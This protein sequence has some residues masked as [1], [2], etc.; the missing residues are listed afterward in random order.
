MALISCFT[1]PQGLQ[2]MLTCLRDTEGMTGILVVVALLAGWIAVQYF[3]DARCVRQAW[4]SRPGLPVPLA[5]FGSA[6]HADAVHAFANRELYQ[7]MLAELE[8]AL[9]EEGYALTRDESL[10]VTMPEA[11]RQK[12]SRRIFLARQCYTSPRVSEQAMQDNE[13]AAVNDGY[14]GSWLSILIRGSER[15]GWYITRPEN[16][17]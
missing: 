3:A 4:E 13:D 9:T 5:Q 15:I 12:I 11:D 10:C 16:S 14:A 17:Q 8:K 2:G 6:Q 1:S 7:V